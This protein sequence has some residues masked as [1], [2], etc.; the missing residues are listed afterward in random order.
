M[1]AI[2]RIDWLNNWE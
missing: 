1:H 2:D